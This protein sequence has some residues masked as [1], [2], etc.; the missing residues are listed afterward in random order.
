MMK[1]KRKQIKPRR[2]RVPKS[3]S[4]L[5]NL[6]HVSTPFKC[7]FIEEPKLVFGNGNVSVD[8]K[9]GISEFGP[10][11]GGYTPGK[12]I[13][14]GAIGTG[15]AI[16]EFFGFLESCKNGIQAG[17]NNRNKPLDPLT[18]P[19][20][21][22][23]NADKTFRTNFVSNQ[24]ALHRTIHAE[25]F[26]NAV[27]AAIETEKI[28]NV[29]ELLINELTV[30]SKLEPPPD[31][32]V[33]LLPR[34]VEQET[35]H[36][37]AA[38]ARTKVK[39]T[40]KDR[41]LKKLVRQATK[42]GQGLLG[43]Q[44]DDPDAAPNQKAYFNIHH[45]FKARAMESGLPTQLM[46]ESTLRDP[47]LSNVAWNVLTALYYKAG[48]IPWKIQSMP[49]NTCYV[50]V[51]FYKE[52]PFAGAGTQASLAQ[53]FGAGEGIVLQGEKAVFDPSRGDRQP[54]LSE[55][56]AE[57][58]LRRSIELYTAQHK[59]PPT[60]VVVHKTSRYWEDELR[61]FRKGL[62]PV[63]HYDLLALETLNTRFMRIGKKPVIRGSV[64]L[65]GDRHYL[66]YSNGYVPYLRSYPSK[67]IPRPLEIVEH[68]GDS[69]ATT[70]CQEILSLT[71]LNW[72]SCAFG[73]SLPITIRFSKG[74]G[75]ILTEL[76]GHQLTVAQSRYRY[77]M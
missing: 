7:F 30:L 68:H 23:C 61:G 34:E 21:P 71:K 47:H 67:R 32:V 66:L 57:A 77:F 2:K 45:A 72:N 60:R 38:L 19:N 11:G 44:F 62:G 33:V 49:D 6:N 52:K 12:T 55:K 69:T 26:T 31:V 27:S 3:Q 70:V 8:P 75:K 73:S 17:F 4:V 25:L 46:W 35:A 10:F 22:G 13:Q 51:S 28:K 50:G 64:V 63:Y 29:V 48:N 39:L 20:F 43:L 56:N 14:I 59:G 58:L 41:F 42:S 18:Y 53:V 15:E 54:H 65:L 36:V 16:Q 37:G 40:A 24:P 9:S 76:P 5:E 1:T 74:V